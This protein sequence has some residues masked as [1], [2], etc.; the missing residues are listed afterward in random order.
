M[1]L[2]FTISGV[3]RMCE[4]AGSIET[5]VP[6]WGPAQ[7]EGA[8]A[9][10]P[11]PVNTPLSTIQRRLCSRLHVVLILVGFSVPLDIL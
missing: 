3:F 9:Q 5:E 6:Q 10:D 2:G 11:C 8:R 7:R 4:G 1:L